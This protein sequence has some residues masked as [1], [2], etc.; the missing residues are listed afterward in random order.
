[1]SEITCSQKHIVIQGRSKFKELIFLGLWKH[2][3]CSI[4]SGDIFCETLA[5]YLPSGYFIPQVGQYHEYFKRG[6]V[7]HYE[8]NIRRK[9]MAVLRGSCFFC[10][11]SLGCRCH[12]YK[13]S[14]QGHWSLNDA[15]GCYESSLSF[16]KTFYHST[17]NWKSKHIDPKQRFT[18]E[19]LIML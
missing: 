4:L 10:S 16:V 3:M 1:M 5:H 15:D 18:R 11:K 8:H 17:H 12:F 2:L 7:Y 6:F 13:P 9:K 19:V 14:Q